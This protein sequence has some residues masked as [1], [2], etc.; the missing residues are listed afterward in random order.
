MRH[1]SRFGRPAAPLRLSG[2]RIV[3]RALTN[4][5]F[6]AWSE[7]RRANE[8]WL[9]PWEPRRAAGQPDPTV[10]EGAFAARC[11]ARDRD[12]QNDAAYPFGLFVDDRFAGE[13]NLNNIVR[14]ALQSGTVGYWIDRRR[15]GHGYVAEAV[16]VLSSFAFEQIHLHRLEICIV[17][18]N[19]NSRR[20]MDKLQYRCEGIAER[21]LEIDGVWED[22]LRYAITLEEWERRCDE[23]AAQW[24]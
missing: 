12:R 8:D 15:A 16:V 7:V 23:L 10:D 9:L 24:L 21:F 13:V 6:G 18:R 19:V 2:R 17:P 22:H 4:S 14:G 3:L 5:D 1:P 20:V 11:A